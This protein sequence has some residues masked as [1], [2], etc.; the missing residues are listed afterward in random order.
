MPAIIKWRGGDL[1]LF[2]L[3]HIPLHYSTMKLISALS[4][5]TLVPFL[6]SAAPLKVRQAPAAPGNSTFSST[7]SL[8]TNGSSIERGP[9][10]ILTV[11]LQP[12]SEAAWFDAS[13][14]S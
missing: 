1:Q 7:I 2:F 9:S 13:S 11:E 6:A 8:P 3:T 14:S 4:A 10:G 12:G 5:L